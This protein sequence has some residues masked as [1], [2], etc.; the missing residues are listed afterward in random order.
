MSLELARYIDHTLLKPNAVE[1]D[2]LK[3]CQEAKKY[4][5]Y[6]V[7]VPSSWTGT[8]A[9]ELAGS[10]VKIAVVAGFP[11]GNSLTAVKAFEAERAFSLGANEI[12][13]VL[14]IGRLKQKNYKYID[15][16]LQTVVRAVPRAIIKVIIETHLLTN[17]EKISACQLIE[18]SGAHF[19]KTCTGFATDGVS[20]K[21]ELS[22]LQ[23]FIKNCSDKMK[24]KMSGGIKTSQAAIQ[25]I[26][27]GAL[28]IGTSSGVALV[29]GV[30]P[31]GDY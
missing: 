8:V 15:S 10:G 24:Y 2:Y 4:N 12:D 16:E 19:I 22:D 31:N 20:G 1:S 11:L 26:E 7:C 18:Q 21:A 27:A 23:L 3:L 13:L 14:N 28:R 5:F 9:T 30:A 6:A 29:T 25:F 17:S